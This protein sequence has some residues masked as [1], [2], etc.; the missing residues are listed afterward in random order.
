MGAAGA[1]VSLSRLISSL[2]QNHCRS[3]HQSHSFCGQCYSF[4]VGVCSFNLPPFIHPSP[5]F[6]ISAPLHP[7]STIDASCRRPHLHHPNHCPPAD[8]ATEAWRCV[9]NRSPPVAEQGDT[10]RSRPT[11]RSVRPRSLVHIVCSSSK[12]SFTSISW[13]QRYHETPPPFFF[14]LVSCV[15]SLRRWRRD[16]RLRLCGPLRETRHRPTTH[17]S[18]RTS[19]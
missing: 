1:G 17:L 13:E 4:R 14:P 16:P 19:R 8:T 10:R 12:Q 3:L 2:Q 18:F 7:S 9:P 11:P 6:C 15:F 5:S